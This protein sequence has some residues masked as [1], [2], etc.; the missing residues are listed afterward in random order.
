MVRCLQSA[1]LHLIL[2][3]LGLVHCDGEVFLHG[4]G[5]LHI[6]HLQ[7]PWWSSLRTAI[8]AEVARTRHVQDQQTGQ[9]SWQ[10][11]KILQS[12]EKTLTQDG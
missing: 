12:I 5:A 4:H 10:S 3:H 1:E 11:E 9:E 2:L 7:S 6:G 8:L